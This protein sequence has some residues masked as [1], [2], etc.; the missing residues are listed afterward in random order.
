V[1]AGQISVTQGGNV[2][3]LMQAG[4]S[5]YSGTVKNGVTSQ[6]AGASKGSF[7]FTKA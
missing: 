6:A 2:V 3:I 7:S 5:S 4:R 1:H